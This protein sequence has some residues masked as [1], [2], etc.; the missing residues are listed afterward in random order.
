VASVNWYKEWTTGE[1]VTGPMAIFN[2][3]LYFATYAPTTAGTAG[4]NDGGANLYA[5]DFANVSTGACGGA[6]GDSGQ[7]VGCGGITTI[8]P[9]F[10]A[11]GEIN[12]AT[13]AGQA[14]NLGSNINQ[15]TV[16]PGVSVVTASCATA[17]PLA[18]G[19][20]VSGASHTTI[21][22]PTA[23]TYSLM[24]NIGKGKNSSTQNLVKAT[25]ATPTAPTVVDSWATLA[26]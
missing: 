26:E 16:I 21:S 8:D 6:I 17:T 9:G 7:P 14:Q 20:T 25:L 1:R 15:N 12:Y 19:D 3:A 23:P 5:W 2:G 18:G 11:T 13:L 4:C 10:G 22:N 24:A